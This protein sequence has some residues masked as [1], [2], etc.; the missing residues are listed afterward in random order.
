MMRYGYGMYGMP[1][2]GLFMIFVWILLIAALGFALYGFIN[3]LGKNKVSV[4]DRQVTHTGES[5]PVQILKER[6]AKGEITQEQYLEMKKTLEE[7]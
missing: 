3:W 2:G 5:T 7:S 6:F 1:G 4:V